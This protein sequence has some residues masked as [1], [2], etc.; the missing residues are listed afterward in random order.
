MPPI[1]GSGKKLLKKK[2]LEVSN[3]LSKCWDPVF[4]N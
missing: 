3:L 2:A 1:T 4:I